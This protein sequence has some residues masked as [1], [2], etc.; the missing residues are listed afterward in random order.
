[1]LLLVAAL[2]LVVG[3]AAGVPITRQPAESTRAGAPSAPP[4]VTAAE[5]ACLDDLKL[6]YPGD[7]KC[8]QLLSTGPCKS[9]EWLVLD[10]RAPDRLRPV[11]ARVP[12]A[13]REVLWPRDGR[14]YQRFRDRETLCP[15]PGNL[16]VSNPF[17]LGECACMR[18]QPH[19]RDPANPRD[20]AC[21]KLYH[22]GPC[23]D[24]QLLVPKI[25][26]TAD[27]ALC[28][29]DP[30]WQHQ[31]EQ[32]AVR[33]LNV[34][35]EDDDEAGDKQTKSAAVM[36]LVLWPVEGGGDGRCHPLG[37]TE[38]CPEQSA[39]GVHP[40]TLRP[41]CIS[42][43]NHLLPPTPCSGHMCSPTNTAS[44][45]D[46]YIKELFQAHKS[47]KAQKRAG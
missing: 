37:A 42:R 9:N 36:P 32:R 12:C 39:F 3:S 24:G 2:L 33:Q 46:G 29:R 26:G 41:G 8:Y 45:S 6:L 30:C 10:P 11:C 23:A 18:T 40:Q 20:G 5:R 31:P 17:G 4:A 13:E 27:Q 47:H 44:Y 25:N 28:V 34:E 43:T 14:C 15:H 21:Y 1:M 16:L 19:A 35:D 38:P 22:R 7:N